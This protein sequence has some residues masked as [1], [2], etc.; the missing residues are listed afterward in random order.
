MALFFDGKYDRF[1]IAG[2]CKRRIHP[3]KLQHSGKSMP[4]EEYRHRPSIIHTLL[5]IREAWVRKYQL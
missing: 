1:K 5:T 3:L 2:L 4:V